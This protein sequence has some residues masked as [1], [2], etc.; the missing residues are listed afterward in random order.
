MKKEGKQGKQRSRESSESWE[1]WESS[2]SRESREVE[3][4]G[5][6]GNREAARKVERV[7]DFLVY[8]SKRTEFLKNLQEK[9]FPSP[10][11]RKGRVQSFLSIR[12]E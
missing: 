1:S 10:E 7:K 4:E 6:Q 9:I 12:M 2:A 11:R 8:P 3:K 5:M